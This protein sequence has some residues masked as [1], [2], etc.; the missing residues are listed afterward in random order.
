MSGKRDGERGERLP[1]VGLLDAMFSC[2]LALLACAHS[3]PVPHV[4]TGG[5]SVPSFTE[6]PAGELAPHPST[7]EQLRAGMPLGATLVFEK[8]TAGEAPIR[9]RWEVTANDETGMTIRTTVVD[10]TGAIVRDEGSG[11]ASWEELHHHADFLAAENVREESSVTVP[12]GT[13]AT[14]H[15]TVRDVAKDT[16][17]RFHFAK[18]LPGP[19][20]SFTIVQGKGT[21]FEMVLIEHSQA[22]PKGAAD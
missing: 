15:Y 20:V 1:F 10:E 8:R 17:S 22:K 3:P 5:E 21:V 7:V 18:D 6:A 4:Q 12:A 16:V 19:P 2:W 14:W 13:F 11:T 9:E